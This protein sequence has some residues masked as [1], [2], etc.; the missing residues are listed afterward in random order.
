MLGL[1][2]NKKAVRGFS[3]NALLEILHCRADRLGHISEAVTFQ[4]RDEAFQG[5]LNEVRSFKGPSAIH[6]TQ[7]RSI[8]DTMK[9]IR[10]IEDAA[11]PDNGNAITNQPIDLSL[12]FDG[13][14]IKRL[15]TNPAT[16]QWNLPALG[17]V[18]TYRSVRE[19]HETHLLLET[20]IHDV[21]QLLI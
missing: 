21:L 7:A 19:H 18:S 17:A 8:G 9:E 10:P 12:N 4:S 20:N 15:T 1:E 11:D 13:E 6:L 2:P 14:I 16:I 5:P 3:T